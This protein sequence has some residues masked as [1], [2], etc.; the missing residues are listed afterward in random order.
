VRGSYPEHAEDWVQLIQAA[1]NLGRTE[2]AQRFLAQAQQEIPTDYEQ[3][4]AQPAP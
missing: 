2:D 4:L 1:Q 3:L